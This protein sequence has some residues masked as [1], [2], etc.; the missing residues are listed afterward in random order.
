MGGVQPGVAFFVGDEERRM[1]F[2]S[3]LGLLR[4]SA[5]GPL[6]YTSQAVTH[7]ADAT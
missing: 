4:I 6:V 1:F 7:R 3:W 5:A 2:E